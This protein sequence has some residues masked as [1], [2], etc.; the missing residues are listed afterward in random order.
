MASDFLP[1][2]RQSLGD[3]EIAAVAEVLRGDWLTTGPSV[4]R[5][6]ADL[7]EHLGGTPAVAVTSGTAALHVAYAAAGVGA[8]DEVVTSPL[9]FVATAA[10]AALHGAKV[11][12]ADVEQD[13]GNLDPEAARAAA[14]PNTRVVAAVDYAG[15]PADLDALRTVAES[16]DALLLEDAAHSI[17]GALNGRPVGSIA[18]VT[19]FSFFATKNLTTAEGG[20]VASPSPDL[21]ANA[22]AFRNHGLVREKAAQRY[23]DEG[24]WHQEVHAFGLNYRLPDVLCALGIAQL[25]KLAAFKSRRAEIHQRYDKAFAG[26]DQ[27]RTPVT[28]AGADPMWHLYPLRARD[29]RRK[30]LF[31]HLR[32]KGIGVQVNYIPAY[33]HPVFEDLGYRRGLCPNAERYYEEELSLPLFPGLTD[34]DVDRVIDA[35]REFLGA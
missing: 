11:V 34:S 4:T 32:S 1:Y 3:D 10:T 8:G 2:G 18:D 5:F 22:A 31:E 30:A 24:D 16:A 7:A 20:A 15:H 26:L 13:T 23:P 17:G 6:E 21:L 19:T 9:T 14:G 28:R 29:G 12:F 33:W 35:V 27:V 25:R